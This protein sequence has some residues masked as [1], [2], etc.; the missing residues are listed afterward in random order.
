[1]TVHAKDMRERTHKAR[2]RGEQQCISAGAWHTHA[3]AQI[4]R[5]VDR[6]RGSTGKGEAQAGVRARRNRRRQLQ[7]RRGVK[8]MGKE[9]GQCEKVAVQWKLRWELPPE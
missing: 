7:D 9:E 3:R 6:Y 5:E 1:M 2:K 4:D 8:A